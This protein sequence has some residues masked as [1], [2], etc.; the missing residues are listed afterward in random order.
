[1][2]VKDIMSSH[3]VTIGPEE[4]AAVAARMLSRHNVGILPVCGADG[5][6]VGVVTDRDIVL[7]FVAAEKKPETTPVK[8]VMTSRVI[9]V[10]PEDN[11]QVASQK[12]AQEQIRRILVLEGQK[13]VGI[14][15]LGDLTRSKELKMEV[16]Q[17]IGEICSNIKKR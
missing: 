5:C 1:M 11:Y 13:V 16:A 6:L 10:S 3:V 15:S 8:N 17:C 4:N 7:R 12:M 9:T 14:V 2:Q